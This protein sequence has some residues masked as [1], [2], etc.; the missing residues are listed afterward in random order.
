[1]T[2]SAAGCCLIDY[3]YRNVPYDR[4]AFKKFQSKAA[5]DGGIIPGG[6]VFAEDLA[7][8]SG[9]AMP[10]ILREVLGTATADTVNLGG[11]AIIALINTAQLL[12]GTGVKCRF[13]ACVGDDPAGALIRDFIARTPVKASI[14]T[15]PGSASPSTVVLADP[16][17]NGGNGERSFINTIGAA[18]MIRP[19]GLPEDFFEADIALFGGT[20][21]TPALHDGLTPMLRRA[22]ASG[23]TT[24]VG[25]VYDFRNER[26]KPADPWPLGYPDACQ[27]I[28]ILV[29]DAGEARRLTQLVDL[30]AAAGQFIS[31]GVGALVITNGEQD[32]LAW[33]GGRIF[34]P[35]GL[36]EFPVSEDIRNSLRDNPSLFADTTG[37]GDNFLGGVIASL[38]MQSG[39][40]RPSLPLALAWGAASGG[41]ACYYP[42]GLFHETVAGEKRGKIQ[43]LAE[44]YITRLRA[45]GRVSESGG[46]DALGKG[47]S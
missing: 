45:S 43:P 4:L 8:F 23:A 24:V 21:L 38:A 13:H 16:S 11:P 44:S 18:G 26:R 12:Y 1:V 17:Q 30:R 35:L 33:S 41:Y 29:T 7:A 22:K 40:C 15:M 36:E 10:E 6:L 3:V 28:D 42:G 46:G 19:E 5:G 9:M 14:V 32:M 34:R 31:R 27:D 20:A 37:C 47:V 39:S 2:I 25:T